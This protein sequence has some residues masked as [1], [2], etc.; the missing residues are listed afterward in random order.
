LLT[1]S[2]SG[3]AALGIDRFYRIGHL[4]GTGTHIDMPMKAV[5]AR[6]P[7][8]RPQEPAAVIWTM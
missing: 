4:Y 6:C 5:A 2:A 7:H 3:Y 8:L 1:V